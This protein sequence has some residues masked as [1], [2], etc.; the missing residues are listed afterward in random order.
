[1]LR[2]A[3]SRLLTALLQSIP[4]DARRRPINPHDQTLWDLRGIHIT[5]FDSDDDGELRHGVDESYRLQVRPPIDNDDYMILQAESV[6]GILHGLQTLLQLLT[7]G[8]F[9]ATSTAGAGAGAGAPVYTLTATSLDIVDFPAFAYRGLLVDTSRHYL[10]LKLLL[11]NLDAMAMNKMNV[12]HWHMVDS[13]SWPFQSRTF[14]ELSDKG[15]YCPN[16]DCVYTTDQVAQVIYEAKLRGI[17]VVP[18]FDL[19]GHSQAIGAS[20]PELLTACKGGR[21]EPLDVTQDQVYPFV[22]QLY[23]EINNTFADDWI[24]IGGDEVYLECW[25][26]NPDIQ[27]WKKLRNMTRDEEVL[28]YFETKLLS[29]I[30]AKIGKR[31]IAWQELFD[32]GLNI[33]Q[34]VVVDVWKEWMY[35]GTMSNAT[36]Q[37]FTVLVSYCWY[38]DHLNEDIDHFYNCDPTNFPGNNAQKKLVAGGHASMWGER[39]DENDFFP[40]VW[41]RTSAVAERLWTGNSES[42]KSSYV[43][44]LDHFRCHMLDRGIPVAPLHPGTCYSPVVEPDAV[45]PTSWDASSVF[46]VQ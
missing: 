34:N 25:K 12:L 22:Y 11:H 10:P 3:E 8:W 33:P 16:T 26:D 17:R 32:S 39:V 30:N 5:I 20:H 35:N 28:Q 31:P 21:S 42:A 15:A 2:Q 36:A 19:P 6:W 45:L 37:G 24:H 9:D 4:R 40:R 23:Q 18:E 29:Y 46:S 38:L 27:K 7:F 14:P 13:Q 43:E 41:P 1:M 44:R